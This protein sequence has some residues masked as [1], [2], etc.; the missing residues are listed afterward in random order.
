MFGD[1]GHGFLFIL[2]GIYLIMLND[3]SS[4]YNKYKYMILLMGLFSF[5]CGLVYNEFLAVP[6]IGLNSCYDV[7]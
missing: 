1:I 6:F 2:L 3:K 7:N 4:D 5:Y